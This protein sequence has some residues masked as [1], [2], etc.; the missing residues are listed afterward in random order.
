MNYKIIVIGAAIALL[1]MSLG[2]VGFSL[3]ELEQRSAS[4]EVAAEDPNGLLSL[5]PGASSIVKTNSNGVL[6]IN[7][8]DQLGSASGMNPQARLEL[9]D[10]TS[11]APEAFSATN[12]YSQ[13]IQVD[14]VVENIQLPSDGSGGNAGTIYL[15]QDGNEYNLSQETVPSITLTPGETISYSL[16]FD[17]QSPAANDAF[18]ADLTF[19]VNEA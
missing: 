6:E 19:K 17:S 18:N 10:N 1:S 3:L 13:D 5:Q 15:Y 8:A 4:V 16:H 11:S 7:L 2:T 14:L 9:G 12:G